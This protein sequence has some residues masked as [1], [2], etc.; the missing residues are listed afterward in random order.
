MTAAVTVLILVRLRR[1]RPLAPF[2]RPRPVRFGLADLGLHRL[3]CVGFGLE[4]GGD[5]IFVGNQRVVPAGG[6][7]GL[8]VVTDLL[9]PV[10]EDTGALELVEHAQRNEFALERGE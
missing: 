6:D 3:D 8:K 5:E 9:P 10:H 1:R 7:D 4:E 2:R